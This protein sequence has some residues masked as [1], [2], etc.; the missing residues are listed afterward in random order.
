[1]WRM[2]LVTINKKP[3][4]FA[5]GLGLGVFAIFLIRGFFFDLLR[6]YDIHPHVACDLKHL[7]RFYSLG[8]KICNS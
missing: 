7:G 8:N 2:G 4:A 6:G 1:M 5:K 3:L